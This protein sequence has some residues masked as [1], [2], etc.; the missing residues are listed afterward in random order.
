M[1]SK[2]RPATEEELRAGRALAEALDRMHWTHADL[3]DRLQVSLGL[4][5]QWVTAVVRL[6]ISRAQDVAEL[7]NVAP[8]DICVGYRKLRGQPDRHQVRESAAR[9]SIPTSGPVKRLLALISSGALSSAQIQLLVQNAEA[10]A[11]A[12]RSPKREK[13][14]AVSTAANL[15]KA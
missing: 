10:F 15:K 6:P 11:A 13:A 4:I 3:A 5:S 1:S 9:Y 12:N 8:S 2:R 14:A 7:L